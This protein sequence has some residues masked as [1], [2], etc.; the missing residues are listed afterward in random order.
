MKGFCGVTSAGECP[1]IWAIFKQCKTVQSTREYLM[2]GMDQW[3]A[4]TGNELTSNIMFSEEQM[5]DISCPSIQ[6]TPHKQ[7]VLPRQA[8]DRGYP[9]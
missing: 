7:Q 9:I 5:K 3:A 8:I 1:A 4:S 2:R 6:R